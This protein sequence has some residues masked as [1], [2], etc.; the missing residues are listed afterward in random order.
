MPSRPIIAGWAAVSHLSVSSTVLTGTRRMAGTA[1]TATGPRSAVIAAS[2]AATMAATA[3]TAAAVIAAAAAPTAAAP[4]ATV[5][6][7]AAATAAATATAVVS[8][9]AL[10]VPDRRHAVEAP[11]RRGHCQGVCAHRENEYR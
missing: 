3:T 4:T 6:A 8:Q 9:R 5:I 10:R 11:G 1:R 2:I 7:A